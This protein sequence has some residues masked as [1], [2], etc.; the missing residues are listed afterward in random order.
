MKLNNNSKKINIITDEDI[1]ITSSGQENNSLSEILKSHEE[2]IDKLKS[3]VKWLYKYGGVGSGGGSGSG[4]PQ[5]TWKI[6]I[7]ID[8]IEAK[9]GKISYLDQNKNSTIIKISI[10]GG[11]S[12]YK[13]SGSY[14]LNNENNESGSFNFA[15]SILSESNIWEQSITTTKL[16]DN[17]TLYFT[18]VDQVT[19]IKKNIEISFIAKSYS[20]KDIITYYNG[21]EQSKTNVLLQEDSKT[22]EFS[23]PYLISI[24]LK[25]LTYSWYLDGELF[26]NT[27]EILEESDTENKLK[28]GNIY[29]DLSHLLSND[30]IGGHSIFCDIRLIRSD[31]DT[32][33]IIISDKNKLI[34]ILP[35]NLYLLLKTKENLISKLPTNGEKPEKKGYLNKPLNINVIPYNNT[36]NSSNI[37]IHAE[38][39]NGVIIN[40][41][42][43]WTKVRES[44]TTYITV[45]NE[46]SLPD[47]VFRTTGEY[48]STAGWKKIIL[49]GSLERNSNIT[50]DDNSHTYYIYIDDPIQAGTFYKKEVDAIFDENSKKMI[51]PFTTYYRKGDLGDNFY[52]S[53]DDFKN[54]FK[55]GNIEITEN[56]PEFNI[57]LNK[58]FKDE[59]Y[60]EGCGDLMI[61]IGINYSEINDVSNPILSFFEKISQNQDSGK[62]FRLYQDKISSGS[63]TAAGMENVIPST[64]FYLNKTPSNIYS[65]RTEDEK[66]YN[67][68]QILFADPH[69]ATDSEVIGSIFYY[70]KIYIYINGV[71]ESSVESWDS[72][73]LSYIDKI[74]FHSGN[75]KINLLDI[76]Y[77]PDLSKPIKNVDLCASYYYNSYIYYNNDIDN[78]DESRD[79]FLINNLYSTDTEFSIVN[80]LLK[81]TESNVFT[82][83]RNAGVPSLMCELNSTINIGDNNISILDWLTQRVLSELSADQGQSSNSIIDARIPI[84]IL[85]WYNNNSDNV[86]EISGNP[87]NE[88][89]LFEDEVNAPGF[90]LRL[91]GSTTLRFKSKNFTLG[92]VEDNSEDSSGA[93]YLFSP[94]FKAITESMTEE[95]KKICY[96]TFL[97]EKKF[98]LK[99][100]VIDSSH[101]NNCCIG[102]FIN[103][104]S[105][106]GNKKITGKCKDYIKSCLLGFPILLFLK[107]KNTDETNISSYDYYCLGI[108]NFNLGRESETN[109]GYLNLNLDNK[110][111]N[112]VKI[113]NLFDDLFTN[114]S[115][116]GF[117]GY[118]VS[119][120][121]Y[122]K[123]EQ[124]NIAEIQ[125][126]SAVFDFHQYD[127]SILFSLTDSDNS[128]MFGNENDI[129]SGTN[130]ITSKSN[131]KNFVKQ[132]ALAG[133]YIFNHIHKKFGDVINSD[134]SLNSNIGFYKTE[135]TVPNYKSQLIRSIKDNNNKY[136][137]GDT[138]VNEASTTDLKTCLSNTIDGNSNTPYLDYTT[139]VIYYTTC[140]AFGL[141]DSVQKNLT[142]K[143]WNDRTFGIYFYDMDT[144]FGINNEGIETSV[145]CFS[146]YW[147]E[148]DLEETIFD[149]RGDADSF[150]ESYTVKKLNSGVKI[151]R[152]YVSPNETE[153]GFDVAS[154]YLFAIAKYA[155]IES[156]ANEIWG[157]SGDK[158]NITFPQK[159]WALWRTIPNE[160][161]D[162]F[163]QGI[164]KSGEDFFNN[165]YK[166][167]IS[168]IPKILISLNYRNKYLYRGYNCEL[169][170]EKESGKILYNFNQTDFKPFHGTRQNKVKE[171][172]KLRFRL[173]D[174]YFNILGAV[175]T[176]YETGNNAETI[177][178]PVSND[179]IIYNNPDIVVASDIFSMAGVKTRRNGD[180]SFCIK[181]KS[182]FSPIIIK[183]QQKVVRYILRDKDTIYYV[184]KGN[185]I[186]SNQESTIGGSSEWYKIN[187][188]NSFINSC[189]SNNNGNSLYINSTNLVDVIL[190]DN[191]G[192]NNN[193]DEVKSCYLNV[194]AAKSV[195]FN[196]LLFEFKIEIGTNLQ[197]LTNLDISNTKISLNMVSGQTPPPIKTIN[198]VSTVCSDVDLSM[199][200]SNKSYSSYLEEIKLGRLNNSS[201]IT[202][203]ENFTTPTWKNIEN[204]KLILTENDINVINLKLYS[205]NDIHSVEIRGIKDLKTLELY[206]FENVT[207]I[208]CTNLEKIVLQKNEGDLDLINISITN[209]IKLTELELKGYDNLPETLNLSENTQLSNVCFDFIKL[210]EDGIIEAINEDEY[211]NNE[212]SK[213]KSL[214]ISSTKIK[215][216]KLGN[217][218]PKVKYYN[219]N[220][221]SEEIKKTNGELVGTEMLDLT[222]FTG[223]TS[224]SCN[225]NSSIYYIKFRNEENKPFTIENTFSGCSNLRRIFGNVIINTGNCFK[226][227]YMFSILGLNRENSGDKTA[228]YKNK[229]FLVGIK[230]LGKSVIEDSGRVKHPHEFSGNDSIVDSNGLMKFQVTTDENYGEVTNMKFKNLIGCFFD[231]STSIFDIYY[232]FQNISTD[233]NSINADSSFFGQ[234]YAPVDCRKF[235]W[236][237]TYDNSPSKYLF[238]TWG[239]KINNISGMFLYR[240]SGKIK[241]FT[242]EFNN[243]GSIKE[244]GLYY[245]LKNLNFKTSSIGGTVFWGALVYTDKNVLRIDKPENTDKIEISIGFL[246]NLLGYKSKYFLISGGIN[247]YKYNDLF[248][249]EGNLNNN[250]IVAE[251]GNFKFLGDVDGILND[252]KLVDSGK[253]DG[254]L[255]NLGY[256]NYDTSNLGLSIK[257]GCSITGLDHV[258]KSDYACGNIILSNIF[259]DSTEI[260]SINDSFSVENS[261]NDIKAVFDINKDALSCLP[262]KF[263]GFYRNNVTDNGDGII[264]SISLSGEGIDK[265]LNF[266]TNSNPNSSDNY[267]S[268][269]RRFWNLKS[270]YGFFSGARPIDPAIPTKLP[271][272]IFS[273]NEN[274]DNA[275][276]CFQNFKGEITLTSLGFEKCT[277][278]RNLEG[279]FST[280]RSTNYLHLITKYTDDG[281]EIVEGNRMGITS[282]IPYKFFYHGDLLKKLTYTGLNNDIELSESWTYDNNNKTVSIIINKTEEDE[283]LKFYEISIDNII[284][285][286]DI[287]KDEESGEITSITSPIYVK[288]TTKLKE[289]SRTKPTNSFGIVEDYIGNLLNVTILFKETYEIES[290]TL[291]LT[292]VNTSI[293]NLKNCFK[294]QVHL[295][296]YKYKEGDFVDNLDYIPYKYYVKNN[297]WYEKPDEDIYNL[298]EIAIWSY[299]GSNPGAKK[300][301]EN[302]L[303]IKLG[304]L[305]NESQDR[306]TTNDN[307]TTKEYIRI[308]KNL[309]L[310]RQNSDKPITLGSDGDYNNTPYVK[311]KG[312][313]TFNFSCPPD[314]FRYCSN[315][316]SNIVNISGVFYGCGYTGS[317]NIKYQVLG[318]EIFKEVNFNNNGE[319]GI[320]GRICPYLL[321]PISNV[322]NISELFSYNK[323]LNH[324]EHY[325]IITENKYD[326]EGNIIDTF[327]TEIVEN[328]YLIPEDFFKYAPN[329]KNLTNTFAGMNWPIRAKLNVFSNLTGSLTLDG[330]FNASYFA[331]YIINT[332]IVKQD[333]TELEY[334]YCL[335]TEI[336]SLFVT[337]KISSASNV[338]KTANIDKSE[339]Y[340]AQI[341]TGSNLY[342]ILIFGQNF[343]KLHENIKPRDNYYGY[344]IRKYTHIIDRDNIVLKDG[345]FLFDFNLED[346]TAEKTTT[347]DK[348]NSTI[349]FQ[350]CFSGNNSIEFNNSIDKL[351]NINIYSVDNITI[352]GGTYNYAVVNST[353]W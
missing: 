232:T 111:N 176:V 10:N 114:T 29:I 12:S 148:G 56:T 33:E 160:G 145:H 64:S 147:Y 125:N 212:L 92:L 278:I 158:D 240:C 171:W 281:E 15:N 78:P 285:P 143:S 203:I 247:T 184:P 174:A 236:T 220:D 110:E 135:N 245:Y 74:I 130:I 310:P 352:N 341:T 292:G 149:S 61:S 54:L 157:D 68:V 246:N 230:Y 249:N 72:R 346:T 200:T 57:N 40:K 269:F 162:N 85:S 136:T 108:Y 190:T 348:Y 133:G 154:N 41:E 322:T 185:V 244:K 197:N 316:S 123:E 194:P 282:M 175:T 113:D 91:Q 47:I 296:Y 213:L 315:D 35:K 21:T 295:K 235:S 93:T 106:T 122:K 84:N 163:P 128:S 302:L 31:N 173:L 325:S 165:Y 222:Y 70:R 172:L 30:Y 262:D 207:V 196:N 138:P 3:N 258:L 266:D 208:N 53:S 107:I 62:L 284:P 253:I 7:S 347:Y 17:G 97:P 75:Y 331:P 132:V 215:T 216:I 238:K 139:A 179:F 168:N 340:N 323:L 332:Q 112:G 104:V 178:E 116:N 204:K 275:A 251:N 102:K 170:P 103:Q 182:D 270:C 5:Q 303:D 291:N 301:S 290:R 6:S 121:N 151:L 16:I 67:L 77:F 312:L 32:Q 318:D 115:K 293:R 271:G 259:G 27:V 209:N 289:F 261:I 350:N 219:L 267:S 50:T 2:N 297:T 95:E 287:T 195:K 349:L 351:D 188:L 20:F 150:G 187:S 228:T 146:D 320:T 126:N 144:S 60:I 66:N 223:L 283:I 279:L 94:N 169:I 164:L 79:Y 342:P 334:L 193:S 335:P 326:S 211:L 141:V 202:T 51:Y 327:D 76:T 81:T 241:L 156:I 314:I 237:P 80:E 96:D 273:K 82:I 8:G 183:D 137:K 37:K 304:E 311:F 231:T 38:L 129:I 14:K 105:K 299:D 337:N 9:E 119:L 339:L 118:K 336:N 46:G 166:T 101:T 180:L 87:F 167:H 343:N 255:S 217:Y 24:P 44:D 117:I 28:S 233:I 181:S 19:N 63:V 89:K 268:I 45:L 206:G 4:N 124:L 298:E 274:L 22:L 42:W 65:Q 260:E 159:L 317:S 276:Y 192:N 305:Q 324:Y 71:L 250:Y 11:M 58:P 26:G 153:I 83:A 43:I 25:K 189:I 39:Y 319:L 52:N 242:T 353:S 280:T 210:K 48:S 127:D 254:L 120:G 90:Y 152:D 344:K 256:L 229:C 99:A 308:A 227:C 294:N 239:H 59:D 1:I 225:K 257:E 221:V 205:R 155:K 272:T 264:D 131:I 49:K 330:I 300:D 199:L 328:S 218:E 100:D 69:T 243:D 329:V 34:N 321:K 306:E 13:I 288:P 313:N 224:F 18:A 86:D 252:F 23:I 134:G 286:T 73:Q 191:F 248:N 338:F 198:L 333:N 265:I 186:I 177:Y 214:N 201:S 234:Y 161:V 345:I 309:I 277:K 98:T 142:I 109:L 55:N 36:D 88:V 226:G 140:M 307:F 263:T